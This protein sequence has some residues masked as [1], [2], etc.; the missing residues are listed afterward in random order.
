MQY[1]VLD[2]CSI[3][4]DMEE[5]FDFVYMFDVF[6]DVPYPDKL[7]SGLLRTLKPGGIL[8]MNDIGVGDSV[9]ENKRNLGKCHWFIQM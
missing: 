8:L 9:T 1:A 2:A 6:H 5:Q 3:P 4:P 7:A